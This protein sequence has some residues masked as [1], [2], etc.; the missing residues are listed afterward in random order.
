MAGSGDRS[1]GFESHRGSNCKFTALACFAGGI[2]FAPRKGLRF[3]A[4][5][6]EKTVTRGKALTAVKPG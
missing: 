2:A 4:A 1:A 6:P 3:S 5:A